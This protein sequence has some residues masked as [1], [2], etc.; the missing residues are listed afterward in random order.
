MWVLRSL[1]RSS[2]L[3]SATSKSQVPRVETAVTS[4]YNSLYDPVLHSYLEIG[5]RS[6][7][8]RLIYLADQLVRVEFFSKVLHATHQ[9]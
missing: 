1:F 6:L 4:C 3:N 2:W 9:L 8:T 5:Q 7:A